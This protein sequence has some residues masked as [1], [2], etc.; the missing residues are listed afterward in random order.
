MKIQ[1]E[2][3]QRHFKK[4]IQIYISKVN[5]CHRHYSLGAKNP[6]TKLNY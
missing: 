1:K 3:S 5:L 6:K 2:N 4:K